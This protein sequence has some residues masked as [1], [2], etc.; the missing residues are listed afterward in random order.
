MPEQKP[1]TSKIRQ[2]IVSCLIGNVD[3]P[4]IS[5]ADVLHSLRKT[6]PLD[7]HTDRE[8]EDVIA[9][10]AVDAG[11]AIEFDGSARALKA[12]HLDVPETGSR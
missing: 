3:H 12:L 1:N 9:L 5:I 8:L 2:A 4:C 11:F 6:L 7:E 10:I